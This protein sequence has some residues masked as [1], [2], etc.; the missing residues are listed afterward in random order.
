M[1]WSHPA[2]AAAVL[3]AE[4]SHPLRYA[5]PGRHVHAMERSLLASQVPPRAEEITIPADVTPEKVPTHIVDY[6]GGAGPL[7]PCQP[8]LSLPACGHGKSIPAAA[9]RQQ[10][11]V[12]ALFPFQSQSRRRTS[13]RRRSLR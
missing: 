7:A 6:S 4:F 5:R 9:G 12:T 13:C 11:S 1:G 8:R 2:H 10:R 3:R